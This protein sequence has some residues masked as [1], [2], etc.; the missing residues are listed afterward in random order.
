[1]FSFGGCS[2]DVD[3]Y[4]LICGKVAVC[5]VFA[6]LVFSCVFVVTTSRMIVVVACWSQ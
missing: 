3:M 5:V 2:A 1:M 6:F 4:R